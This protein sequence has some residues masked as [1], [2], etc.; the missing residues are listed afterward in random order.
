M[1]FRL[2]FEGEI[3]SSQ[4]P[5]KLRMVHNI[6]EQLAPQVEG[7]WEYPPYS[8]VLDWRLQQ[9]PGELSIYKSYQNHVFLPLVAERV[10][11]CGEVDILLLRRQPK[12]SIIS[13]QGDLDNR[14]KMLIDALRAPTPSEVQ[15]L[16]KKGLLHDGPHYCVFHDDNLITNLS[17]NVDRLH[18][19]ASDSI[20]TVAI[21]TV[22]VKVAQ[23]MIGNMNMF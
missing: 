6:R 1:Q 17:I 21:I 16:Q 8:D 10:G 4:N 14:M 12:G 15:A 13:S 3:R 9:P 11:L 2:V 23:A 7:V 22:S 20:K 19:Q 18:G 5:D